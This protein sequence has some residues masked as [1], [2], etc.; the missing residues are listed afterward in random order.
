MDQ[1][2]LAQ[3]SDLLVWGAATAFTLALVAWT[4]EM[5]RVAEAAQRGRASRAQQLDA[6]GGAPVDVPADASH[7][8]AP[9]PRRTRAEGIARSTTGLGLLLLLAGVVT[10]GLAAGRWPT[11]NMYEFAIVGV[12]VA[13]A[14]LTVVQ[15]RRTVAFLAVLVMGIAVL[16]LAV[17]LLVFHVQADEVQPALDSYWLVLHVGVAIA[18]TGVFTVAFAAAVL[19]VLRDSRASGRSHLER[20]WRAADGLRRWLAPLRVTGPRFAWLEQVPDARRLEA[21]SFRLNAIGFVL[22]T[23]TLIGGAIWAEHAWGRYWGWDPKEVGTF[24]A[25]VVYA[26]YLHARTTRGWSGRR[27]AYFVYVGYAVV[28]ANFTVINL[29]V[30]GKHSYSGL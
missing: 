13:V 4:I 25:W 5:S 15:R 6:A 20:P 27:A 1:T 2:A 28:I 17:A 10:R 16:G 14:V 30:D 9:A 7:P 23:F 24:V 22:W 29:L 21:Q 26:A 11:A 3:V 8:A 18:A 19:Q 12:L